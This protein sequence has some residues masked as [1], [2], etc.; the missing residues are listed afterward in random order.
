MTMN[1]KFKTL[2]LFHHINLCPRIQSTSFL[3]YS[4]KQSTPPPWTPAIQKHLIPHDPQTPRI[5]GQPKINKND[6]SLRPAVSTIGAP[7]YA[8][9]HFL[10]EKLHSFIGKNPSFI[11]DSSHFIQ[12]INFFT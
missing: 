3:T 11:K 8:L 12:K 2:F 6:I 1:I 5:Y 9:A 7:T 4:L 10:V